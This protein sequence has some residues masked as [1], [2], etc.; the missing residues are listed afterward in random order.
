MFAT[1]S[2]NFC[3][4]ANQETNISFTGEEVSNP[5]EENRES[6]DKDFLETELLAY[7]SNNLDTLHTSEK[8]SITFCSDAYSSPN[9]IYDNPPPEQ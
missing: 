6:Q 4:N 2:L 1:I 7:I 5:S 9:K 3:V 8:Q